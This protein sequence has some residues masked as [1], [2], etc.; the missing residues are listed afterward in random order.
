[1]NDMFVKH[2]NLINIKT[3][4]LNDNKRKQRDMLMNKFASAH[5][6]NTKKDSPFGT[7]GVLEAESLATARLQ[8]EQRIAAEE[9]KLHQRKMKDRATREEI[10]RNVLESR[11][12]KDL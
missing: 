12:V 10:L 4:A 1:M 3:K 8:D 11:K 2:R 9:S 7:L 5:S 6:G